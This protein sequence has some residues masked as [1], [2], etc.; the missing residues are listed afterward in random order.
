MAN[1]IKIKKG[2]TAPVSGT[3]EVAELG[4]DTKNKKLYV[5]MGKEAPVCV[6]SDFNVPA[7]ATGP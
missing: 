4:F 5:G 2:I 3:L 7:G 6:N 1:T